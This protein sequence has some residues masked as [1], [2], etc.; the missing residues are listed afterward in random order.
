METAKGTQVSRWLYASTVIDPL[1][2]AYSI[3]YGHK[4]PNF[5]SHRVA[6]IYKARE[7]LVVLIFFDFDIHTPCPT[8]SWRAEVLAEFTRP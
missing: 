7:V 2:G 3:K 4:R 5:L 6:M 1:I 8:S